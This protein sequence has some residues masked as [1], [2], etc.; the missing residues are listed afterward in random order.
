MDAPIE[1]PLVRF[2]E[3]RG[4]SRA[5]L[6][7]LLGLTVAMVG[8]VE[9]GVR[10]IGAETAL[11]IERESGVPAAVLRPDLFRRS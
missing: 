10:K 1:H 6:A 7:A 4:L 11:R 3:S 8:H 2:R 9:R 5:E